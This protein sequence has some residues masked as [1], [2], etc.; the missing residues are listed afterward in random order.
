MKTLYALL[1]VCLSFPALADVLDIMPI[2]GD[3]DDVAAV[4]MPAPEPIEEN[5]VGAV[6]D[7][8]VDVDDDNVASVTAPAIVPDEETALAGTPRADADATWTILPTMEDVLDVTIA[9][10]DDAAGVTSAPAPKIEDEVID[11]GHDFAVD[12]EKSREIKLS[13]TIVECSTGADVQS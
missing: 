12:D 7:F 3:D 9:P 4:S 1:F 5:S 8:H 11:H 10:A 13:A 6:V 2:G